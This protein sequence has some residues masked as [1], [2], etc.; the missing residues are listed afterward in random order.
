[1][2][3]LSWR[4]NSAPSVIK[5]SSEMSQTYSNLVIDMQK[6][7]VRKPRNFFDKMPAGIKDNYVDELFLKGLVH[8]NS[9]PA[10][11]INELIKGTSEILL[12]C[13]S[14]VTLISSFYVLNDKSIEAGTEI[15]MSIT[16]SVFLLAYVTHCALKGKFS[17]S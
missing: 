2:M 9:F 17:M 13:N 16:A 7:P 6:T 3:A 14:V 12:V 5:V 1:M 15:I 8:K 10:L 4:D 11:R